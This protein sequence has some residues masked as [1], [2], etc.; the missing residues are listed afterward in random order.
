MTVST[1]AGLPG[2]TDMQMCNINN[3]LITVFVLR[4][5]CKDSWPFS[6][7]QD[8]KIYFFIGGGLRGGGGGLAGQPGQ[9][10]FEGLVKATARANRKAISPLFWR[11]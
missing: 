3:F 10:I 6:W 11:S 4:S 9:I 7:G 1:V 5:K 8:T 2:P